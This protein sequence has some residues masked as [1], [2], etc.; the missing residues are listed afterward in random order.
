MDASDHSDEVYM[1]PKHLVKRADTS[2]LLSSSF[3]G[4]LTGNA[5]INLKPSDLDVDVQ[6]VR[7]LKVKAN[8]P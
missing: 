8:L 2:S 6:P 3:T 1:E 4:L 7:G 5:K